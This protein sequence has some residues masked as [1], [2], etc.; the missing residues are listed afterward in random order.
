MSS[1]S[2]NLLNKEMSFKEN[3]NA[4]HLSKVDKDGSDALTQFQFSYQMQAF[5]VSI[6][7]AK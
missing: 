5:F 3:E 1:L 2:I 4:L 6:H 7:L